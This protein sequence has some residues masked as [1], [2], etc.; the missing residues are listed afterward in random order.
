[1]WMVRARHAAGFRNDTGPGMIAGQFGPFVL[2]D[3]AA[4]VVQALSE[5]PNVLEAVIV[6]V[7]EVE[8]DEPK[9]DSKTD[10]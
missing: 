3:H 6:E 4:S 7:V 2:H 1:M 5:R 8:A 9:G 10:G